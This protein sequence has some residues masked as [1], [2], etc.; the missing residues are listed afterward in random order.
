MTTTKEIICK[1]T[2]WFK[3]RAVVLTLMCLVGAFFFFK[4]WK[5]GYPKKNVKRF[6][7]IAFENAEK[8]FQEMSVDGISATEW[9]SFAKQQRLY[10]PVAD[11][12]KEVSDPAKILPAKE[13]QKDPGWPEILVNFADYRQKY[14][15]ESQFAVP[16]GWKEFAN[17]GGRKWS[18]D[19]PKEL[20]TERTI[21]EQLYIGVL[22]TVLFLVALFWSLRTM[23]RAMKVSAA[24]FQPA[25]KELIPFNAM[26]KIDARKWQTKGLAFL[27][28][29]KDGNEKKARIDGMVYG[30]FKE[31]DGA[32][33]QKLYDEILKNFSGEILELADS[34][35]DEED[36]QSKVVAKQNEEADQ[37]EQPAE[38]A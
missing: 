31:E 8:N 26:R 9:E 34:S 10:K 2:N 29:E 17:S 16:P 3:L 23:G 5:F 18:L 22:L 13:V 38:E 21:K 7:Y 33:A 19:A 20:L 27:F 4:D 15:E 12:S 37:G 14:D 35:E 28:Y 36:E 6:H 11:G 25:G 1:P 24:G 32:P 30:Q